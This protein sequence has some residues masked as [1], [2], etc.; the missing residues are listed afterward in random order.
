MFLNFSMLYLVCMLSLLQ[1]VNTLLKC[2]SCEGVN[3]E[4]CY[5]KRSIVECEHSSEQ[6]LTMSYSHK[7]GGEIKRVVTKK[8]TVWSIHWDG[9]DFGCH[10]PREFNSTDCKP[11]CCDKDLCN[12]SKGS[13]TSSGC[14]IQSSLYFFILLLYCVY[15]HS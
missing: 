14:I 15:H 2:W 5:H 8:C 10:V 13:F 3:E 11:E 6:C 7:E 1:R 4:D 12:T 9:C